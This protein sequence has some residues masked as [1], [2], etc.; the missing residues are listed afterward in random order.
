MRTRAVLAAAALFALSRAP[1]AAAAA[2]PH[3][4]PHAPGASPSAAMQKIHDRINALKKQCEADPTAWQPRFELGSLYLNFGFGKRAAP[5]FQQ[6]IALKPG[7]IP[8]YALCG[9]ALVQAKQHDEAIALWKKALER[10]PG[11]RRLT[12]WIAEATRM[13]DEDRQLA[14]LEAVLA[15]SPGDPDALFRR[16]RIRGGRGDW[17]AAKADLDALLAAK[18]DYADAYGLAGLANYK[19]GLIDAA[20]RFLTQAVSTQPQ[21]P[22]HKVW[23]DRALSVKKV[24]DEL[25]KVEGQLQAKPDD[26]ALHFRA[27]ELWAKL[28]QMPRAAD[29]LRAA[30]RLMPRNVAAHR[31]LGLVLLRLGKMDQAMAELDRAVELDPDNAELKALRDRV[32]RTVGMH[33]AMKGV[34]SGGHGAPTGGTQPGTDSHK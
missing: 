23:L 15:K 10:A 34:K 21:E 20:I 7:H 1:V 18:P 26:G 19:L 16:A 28:G 27:G 11:D 3:A 22:T 8:A 31:G 9:K 17:K 25:A 6:V 32:K 12:A 5:L 29:R 13:R 24:N 4:G 30:V 33:K 2:P 14:E